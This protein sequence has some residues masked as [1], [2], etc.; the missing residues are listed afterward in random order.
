ME[1]ARESDLS[2]KPIAENV[3]IEKLPTKGKPGNVRKLLKKLQKFEEQ[4]DV[5]LP[6]IQSN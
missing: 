2:S 5:Q 3:T 4:N 1:K 6:S